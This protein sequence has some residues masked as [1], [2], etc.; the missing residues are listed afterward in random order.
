[1]KLFFPFWSL[2]TV[3]VLEGKDVKNIL[4]VMNIAMNR[5]K[6]NVRKKCPF[7]EKCYRKNPIH[8]T[9]M[10]HPHFERLVI[11]QLDDTLNIPDVLDFECDRSQL[12]DQ[13][14]VIQIVMRKERDKDIDSFLKL[15]EDL[16]STDVTKNSATSKSPNKVSNL[17]SHRLD[18]ESQQ[19]SSS[20]VSIM[21]TY[22]SCK[23]NKDREE[24]RRKAIKRMKQQGFEVSLV[25]P[26]EFAIKYAL[27]APYYIFFTRIEKS[28][29]T[30]NQSFSITFPEILDKSLGEIKS[31]LQIT[32]MVDVGWLC[33]QYLLAG[34]K[35]NIT[36]LY[37]DRVDKEKLGENITLISVPLPTPYGCHHSKMMILEYSDGGIRIVVSTANLY[38][39]DWE[40]R[41]QG[42]WISPHLP[43]LSKSDNTTNG[44]SKTN[45][46]RDFL[47]YLKTYKQSALN[48][49]IDIVER[50]DFS[51]VNV[52]F[53]ASVPGSYRQT[54]V[55]TWG[56]RKLGYVL[57]TY[58][59]L[60]Q[61]ALHWPIIAQSS[62]LGTLGPSYQ[63]W[64]STVIVSSMS[65]TKESKILPNFQFIFPTQKNYEESFDCQNACCCLCYRR[66][67]HSK[68]EWI[69]DYLYQWKAS[70]TF[71][72]K[73]MP[74]I[75]SYTRLSPDL[76]KMAW[77]VLTSANLSKAAWGT[78]TNYI[79]S[80]EAGVLFLPTFITGE[81]TFPIEKENDDSNIQPF[82][83]PYDLPLIPYEPEDNPFVMDIFNE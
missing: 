73:A 78:Q 33:L 6:V 42:L 16:L 25:E 76:K 20:S 48:K 5:V 29:S 61:N 65:K 14:K 72:D 81:T 2:R 55:D 68:Q 71:R 63:N 19:S 62:S 8:F 38:S 49:W 27:A 70:K 1:M 22:V 18:S 51:D 64:L 12:L 44:E 7:M 23:L 46:K 17:E 24:I 43:S 31:S 80:Y 52:F 3:I 74:H 47:Q 35:A 50:A 59:S 54:N 34:Q 83:I 21:D 9:E 77:F 15:K 60:P 67:T 75:K 58:A 11:D 36:I 40:N 56:H 10:S 79:A 37:G 45:F 4:K 26:G 32:F 13:L 30:Y 41:T 69:Q 82:P 57:S 66:Q 28:L 53:I 39:D